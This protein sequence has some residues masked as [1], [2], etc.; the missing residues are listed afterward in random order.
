MSRGRTETRCPLFLAA[1]PYGAAPGSSWLLAFGFEVQRRAIDA[2]A[3]AGGLWP[4]RKD[5]AQMAAA[6]G[7][8]DLRAGHAVAGVA[9]DFHRLG[10]GRIEAGPTRTAFIFGA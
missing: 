6:A 5:M 4:V 10:H 7:A 1:A 3:L 9:F 8:I 2:I